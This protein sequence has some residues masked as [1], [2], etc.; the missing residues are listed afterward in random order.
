MDSLRVLIA[1]DHPLF[2]Q[3][4]R[5]IIDTTDDIQVVGEASTGEAAISLCAELQ[6]SLV[7]MDVRMPGVNGIEATRRITRAS[8][9]IRV[10]VLTMFE[11]DASVFTAMRAGARGYMLKDAGKDDIL[12]AIRAV[13]GGDA[14]FSSEVATRIIDYFAGTRLAAPREAFPTLTEREREILY[15]LANGQ[16]NSQIA[17]GLSLSQK[18]ISNYVSNIL[19]KLQVVDR[20][21]AILRAREAGLG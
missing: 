10:L 19:G 18:S 2:R 21:A 7:L 20:A 5:T 8:P 3:G 1:D 17:H 15:M 13:A 6:P 14:I 4:L 11:D 16:S 9:Q 12:R